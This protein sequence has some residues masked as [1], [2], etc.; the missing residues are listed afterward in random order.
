M[1]IQYNMAGGSSSEEK[2]GHEQAHGTARLSDRRCPIRPQEEAVPLFF[3]QLGGDV[4][5]LAGPEAGCGQNAGVTALCLSY[6][7]MPP[8]LPQLDKA[9]PWSDS[10][11]G[12]GGGGADL[13]EDPLLDNS[14]H[15]LGVL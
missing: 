3:P 8:R 10:G 11:S 14:E 2:K 4:L 13:L 15:L 6:L 1:H 7:L 9:A 5:C 12:D